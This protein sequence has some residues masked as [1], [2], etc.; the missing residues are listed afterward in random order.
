MKLR[1]GY[2]YFGLAMISLTFAINSYGTGNTPN[3]GTAMAPSLFR[4]NAY[5]S[6]RHYPN[7]SE[8][9]IMS[10][11]ALHQ[12]TNQKFQTDSSSFEEAFQ[13]SHRNREAVKNPRQK[14]LRSYARVTEKQEFEEKSELQKTLK[15]VSKMKRTGLKTL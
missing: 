14:L 9:L 6:A 12:I 4:P 10:A 5:A 7:I 8:I 13:P 15:R 2:T 1:T 3:G 11:L